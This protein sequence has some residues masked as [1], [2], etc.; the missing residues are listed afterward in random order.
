MIFVGARRASG[1]GTLVA[2]MARFVVL[3][4]MPE[5]KADVAMSESAGALNAI[6]ETLRKDLT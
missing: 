2:Q 5:R 4:H 1:I 6:P 3:V